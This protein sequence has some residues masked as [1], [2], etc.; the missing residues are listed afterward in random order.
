MSFFPN[1]C[2]YPYRGSLFLQLVPQ[3]SSYLAGYTLY[4]CSLDVID[5]PCIV[6]SSR[7]PELFLYIPIEEVYVSKYFHNFQ[8]IK[9]FYGLPY[10]L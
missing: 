10:F 2:I 5:I 3:C 8:H 1:S 7:L 6:L 4:L 9:I